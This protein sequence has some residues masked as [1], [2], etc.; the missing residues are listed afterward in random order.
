MHCIYYY[1]HPHITSSYITDWLE[2]RRRKREEE[3]GKEKDE[4]GEMEEESESRV[5]GG[6]GKVNDTHIS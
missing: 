3:G 5:V 1:Y 6:E 4:E 2:G